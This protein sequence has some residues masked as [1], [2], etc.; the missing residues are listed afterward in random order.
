MLSKSCVVCGEVFVKPKS[1]SLKYWEEKRMFCTRQCW[2]KHKTG[3][4]Q[5]KEQIAKKTKHPRVFVCEICGEEI[6]NKRGRKNI[7]FCC[8]RCQAIGTNSGEHFPGIAWNKGLRGIFKHTIKSRKKMS[9]AHRG[10]KSPLWRGGITKINLKIR[11]LLE[12][13]LWREA[14]FARDNYK[15]VECGDAKGGNLQAHHIKC[16]SSILSANSITTQEQ[17]KLC[18][19][20]WDTENGVTLCKNCHSKAHPDLKMI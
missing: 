14:V 11:T 10:A 3:Q 8:R 13:R 18:T 15:C 4:K 17:A 5:T 16:L 20:L 19:E 1:C 9:I 2:Y 7:R 12:Y 6:L